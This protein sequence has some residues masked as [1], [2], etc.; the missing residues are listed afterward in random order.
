MSRPDR[1]PWRVN[2]RSA[3]NNAMDTYELVII[4]SG[5]GGLG[6]ASAYVEAGGAGPVLLLTGHAEAVRIPPDL[7][8][9]TKPFASHELAARVSQ[10]L[11]GGA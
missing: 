8:V 7:P 2:G 6:A 10:L 9:M 4:G 1:H 3:H 5:P 11:D